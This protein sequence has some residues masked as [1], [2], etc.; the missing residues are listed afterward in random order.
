MTRVSL[1][2][3]HYL[4]RQ[5]EFA[6]IRG[7]TREQF[8]KH[9][10]FFEANYHLAGLDQ[11]LSSFTQAGK[12]HLLITFDDG[13]AEHRQ[14]F[15]KLLE[16]RGI[17]GIFSVPSCILRGEPANPQIIRFSQTYFG[18][19]KFYDLAASTIKT[20]FP[21]YQNLLIED[22]G[23]T[24][25]ADLEKRAKSLFKYKL[26]IKIA[27]HILLNLYNKYLLPECPD[28]MQRVYLTQ[29]QIQDLSRAGHVIAVHSDTHPVVGRIRPVDQELWDSEIIA[30]KKA[31]EKLLAKPVEIFTY[32]HGQK[33]EIF[34]DPSPLRS[35][36]YKLVFTTF[37]DGKKFNPLSLGRYQSL[38]LD[39]T[40]SLKE[41]I[42]SY[43][44]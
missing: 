43:E 37:Q 35:A 27:R 9:L 29:K 4:A 44:I 23:E 16:E 6:N 10:D 21:E 2:C 3:Y 42:W 14:A 5:D 32:P 13:L 19:A 7:H 15:A 25:E 31:F 17:R 1:V 18:Y 28:F 39:T 34:E 24:P 20:I 8:E 36:G 33:D 11:F 30:P 40:E 41:K 12:N 26:P 22:A 38:T